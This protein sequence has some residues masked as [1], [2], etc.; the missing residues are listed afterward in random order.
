M[1]PRF[2]S[3]LA[4]LSLLF[5]ACSAVP[6]SW[7]QVKP[8]PPNPQ[9][10][11]LNPPNITGGQRG[12]KIELLLTGTNLAGPTTLLTSFPAK[13]TIPK[14][15]K[16]GED[17]A[18]LK[19]I[20][21]I[22]AD[23][24]IG[25]HQLRLA[26][27]RGISNLRI[28]SV[29]ELNQVLETDKN[30]EKGTAQELPVPCVVN[31]RIDAEKSDWF[32]F[33]AA[34]GQK[35]SF[36]VVGRRI[37]S[38]IDPEL[39]IYDGKGKEVAHDNDSPG[40][41]SDARL[42]FTFKDAGDYFI[43]VR[44]VLY[45]G[46]PEYFYRLRIG[47]FPLATTPLPMAAKR[48]SKVKVDF[49]GPSVDGVLPVDVA[50]P[51]DLHIPA[52]WVTP[53][54]G[55]GQS[56]WPV[57]L[58]LSDLDETIEQEPNNE[59]VKAQRLNVPSG[60]TGRLMPS[61][62]TDMYIFAG[63]KGQK[64][65]IEVETLELHSPSLVF[66]TVKNVKTGAELGKSNPA[67]VPPADQR[68]EFTPADDGDCLIEVQH[69]NFAGG[70]SE[71]YHLILGAAQ[72]GFD[73]ALGLDRFD[74]SAGSIVP[75]QATINRKGY[76]GPIEL[77]VVGGKG[78][79]G[80]TIVPA[81][82]KPQTVLLTVVARPDVPVGAMSFTVLAHGTIDKKRITQLA[83]VKPG[84]SAS[85]GN[86]P[87]PPLNW[88]ADVA[89]AIKERAPFTLEVAL[90]P[91]V[92]VPGLPAT[93]KVTVQRDPGFD[94]PVELTPPGNLPPGVAPP[95]LAPI[96]KDKKDLTF[97]LDI[98][99]K[100]PL[101]DYQILIGAKAKVKGKDITASA[102]PLN[103]VVSAPFTL[104]IEPE[105][106]ALKPGDKAKLKVTAVRQGGYKGPIS[107][108]ARKLPVNVTAGKAVLNP[109]QTTAEIDV[110][111]AAAAAAAEA[112]DVDILG[113]ATALMNLQGASPVITVRVE[114]K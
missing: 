81:A 84:V 18:K 7:S 32:K 101:G 83:S 61:N 51:A 24:P 10:P 90:D 108:E 3:R 40:A 99:A 16:N 73:V 75:I 74:V 50:V 1:S 80:K 91:P 79:A 46:G 8:T 49:A 48:G 23:A 21:E 27:T 82:P 62:D 65:V 43:E 112:K 12:A 20:L 100:V 4:C 25:P 36:E 5:L 56:G 14:E 58:A 106:L 59:A 44:D 102:P 53:K 86:L 17:N 31:A 11:V 78:I 30:Q 38:T 39:T 57:V 33:K 109:D 2:F 77:E 98:N 113:T 13:V 96:P 107:L 26:T 37:G 97:P 34:A 47:D 6:C 9:A 104:K 68:V 29:D 94:E 105:T 110:T 71:T 76:T 93:V 55:A 54:R 85:L 72:P 22:P 69:L 35:L 52:L 88:Q 92:A 42:A 103:V 89:L 111:A 45:R 66:F 114:K 41:Q 64:V 63:K 19:V 67:G 60:V 28:F 95:K 87:Y 70:P 15:D